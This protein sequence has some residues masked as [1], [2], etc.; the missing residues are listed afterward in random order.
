[1]KRLTPL[2]TGSFTSSDGELVLQHFPAL[3]NRTRY[4]LS[5][6]SLTK[7]NTL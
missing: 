2:A 6:S 3:L 5:S 4:F 1:M 7:A